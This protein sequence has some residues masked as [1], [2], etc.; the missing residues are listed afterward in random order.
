MTELTVL[1]FRSSP[2]SGDPACICSLCREGFAEEEIP[3]M[4]FSVDSEDVSW[5]MRY[6]ADC[7]Q[8]VFAMDDHGF[9]KRSDVL[10][11]YDWG[12]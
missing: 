2:D 8:Q 7:F 9:T 5:E 3:I 1:R 4:L 6:H 12:D 10:L 11:E